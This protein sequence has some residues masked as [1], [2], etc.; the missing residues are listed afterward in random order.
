M[1]ILKKKISIELPK[2]ELLVIFEFLAR[3][4]D[5]WSEAGNRDENTFVLSRPDAGER[6]ILW[7]LEGAIESTLAEIFSP[8][9]K[10]LLKIAKEKAIESG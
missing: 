8:E 6:I 9:Y 5:A 10:E 2:G 7:H 4:Y 3:S 1:E